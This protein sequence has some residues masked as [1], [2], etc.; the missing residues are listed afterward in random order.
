MGVGLL[1]CCLCWVL[2]SAW[3][4]VPGLFIEIINRDNGRDTRAASLGLCCMLCFGLCEG[5]G[6]GIWRGGTWFGFVWFGL[7]RIGPMVLV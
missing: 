1:F 6:G 3:G 5:F 7:D 2:A 4:W